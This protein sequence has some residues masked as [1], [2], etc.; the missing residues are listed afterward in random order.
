MSTR[1][2]V[3]EIY[4]EFGKRGLEVVLLFPTRTGLE[5]SI[6]DATRSIASY[7]LSTGLHD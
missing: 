7:F 6:F 5:K 4:E 1:D 2:V 3:S